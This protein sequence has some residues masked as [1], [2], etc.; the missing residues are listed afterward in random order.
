[1]KT[2]LQSQP[3]QASYKHFYMYS[4]KVFGVATKP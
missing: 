3:T 1:M 2:G 4:Q